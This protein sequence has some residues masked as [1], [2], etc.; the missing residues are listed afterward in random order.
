M[1]EVDG[2]ALS[3]RNQRLRPDERRIATALYEALGAVKQQIA[4]GVTDPAR[5]REAG[6]LVIQQRQ[7][8]RLEYLEI[9]D[10]ARCSRSNASR[11]PLSQP[12]RSGSARRG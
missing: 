4:A 5:I 9:V 7:G 3:S 10:P 12:G 11:G 1:R 8:V 2:L 6:E